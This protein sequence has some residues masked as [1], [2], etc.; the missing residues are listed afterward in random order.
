MSDPRP[1]GVFDSGVGGLS[2]WREIAR[3]LPR[4]NI[5]CLADQAHVPYGS[6]R[7]AE[8][9][10]LSESITRFL[11]AQE[12]KI[13]VVACNTAS[14]A[15]LHHLRRTFPSVLFV[16]MEPAIKPAVER[17]DN[18]VVG[19]IATQATFQGKLFASLV[20]RY[21]GN[22]R[23]LTQTCPGLVE[24][25]EAGALNT[26]ETKSLLQK[27]LTPLVEAGVDQLVLGCTHYPFLRPSIEQVI[28]ASV[29]VIDPASAVARQT[30]RVLTQRGIKAN[31]GQKACRVFY[32]SGD[33]ANFAAMI[34]RLLPLSGKDVEARAVRWRAGRIC[35]AS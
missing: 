15:A 18:G 13:I 9:R 17:T 16:G 34:E 33:A 19:V 35:L 11:L 26:P 7:L 24:A 27:Y 29:A 8:V 23:V 30:A 25:V 12:A 20:E 2:V 32:T 4:E 31:Q 28:G 10:A 1:I 21:A 6:R 3:Q 14:A 5:I 22:V